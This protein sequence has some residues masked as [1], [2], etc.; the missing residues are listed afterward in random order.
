MK[1]QLKAIKAL[2]KAS[3]TSMLKTPESI[4]FGLIFPLIF[5]VIFGLIGGN[6]GKLEIYI[7]RDSDKSS[8]VYKVIEKIDSFEL[9][10]YDSYKEAQEDLKKGNL[11][12]ILDI[13]TKA[14]Q[15]ILNLTTSKASPEQGGLLTSVVTGIANTINLES[16]DK[17]R[18]PVS[19]LQDEISGRK[20]KQ[21][22][23]ILPGQLGFALL[24]A[25]VFGTAFAL[26]SL[27]D[28]LV[29]KRFFATPI[30]KS[31]ILVAEGISRLVYSTVQAAVIIAVG[32]FFFGFT[33]I[34][35]I[36]TFLQ[37][38]VISISGLFVFLGIGL[39]ISSVAK[40]QNSVP[41]IANLFTLPQF[42]LSGTFFPI[43]MFPQ[44]LQPIANILPLTHMNNA[45]RAIAFEG[46]KFSEVLPELGVLLIWMIVVYAATAKVFKWESK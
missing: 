25:G 11:A 40:D 3:L 30:A 43:E 33:L 44:W 38:L 2:T 36:P 42:L 26:I 7:T 5:I 6:G 20:Y 37:M 8:P 16:V 22:D 27:R 14:S 19:V 12:G 18:L 13:K 41:T 17:S 15:F 23:F 21:I 32:Y 31:N 39:F 24:S 1:R 29:L 45:L 9:K 34:H 28:T 4:V 10:E 46:A 35:G